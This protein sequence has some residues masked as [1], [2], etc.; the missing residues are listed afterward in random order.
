[1]YVSQ[2]RL[3]NIKGFHGAREVDLTLTRPDGSHA[4]WTVIAGRNGS[5]KSTLLQ[6]IALALGGQRAVFAVMQ[7]FE[8]WITH[9]EESADVD[10]QVHADPDLDHLQGALWQ[11]GSP[12]GLALSWAG[13]QVIEKR[14]LELDGWLYAAYGP[15]RRLSGMVRKSSNR[16]ANISSLFNEDASLSDGVAWLIQQHLRALEGEPG[17]A[18]L[19]RAALRLLSDGLLPD[20]HEV[21]DVTSDG[22]WVTCRGSRFPLRETSDGYRTVT[23]LVVDLLKQIHNAY[24]RL[25]V[26]G[27]AVTAPG[28]VIIDEVDAHLH[29]SW[30]QRIGGWL[31][32][33]LPNIQFIVTTHSPYVCQA[34]DPGGLIRLPGP[35]EQLAPHVVD[36]DLYERVVYGSGDDAVLTELFGLE[37]PYSEQAERLRRRLVELEV[38]VIAGQADEQEIRRYKE[39]RETLTSSLTARADEVAARLRDA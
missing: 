12:F 1:M 13:Q 16:I 38:K 36:Q 7:D 34:A 22:L 11:G 6:A 31:K 5:G 37:S 15:F 9:G 21:D 32:S 39:L 28:V 35:D 25:P 33:H 30:Q 20:D 29:V 2:V 10:L 8:N 18:E 14:S 19:K 23:A 4:G 24:G 27:N 3:R 17:A 26:E